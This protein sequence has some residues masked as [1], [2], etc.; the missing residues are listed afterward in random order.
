MI[1]TCFRVFS[2]FALVGLAA[3]FLSGCGGGASSTPEKD[4]DKGKDPGP[5]KDGKTDLGKPDF[6]L[7]SADYVAEFKKDGKAAHA[8]YKDKVVELTGKIVSVGMHPEGGGLLT[9]EGPDPK[10][11]DWA[12][13]ITTDPRPWK[14]ATPGQTVKVKGKGHPWFPGP[15]LLEGVVESVSGDAAP[16][17]TADEL[18]KEYAA[19]IEA[20]GKKYDSKWIVLSGEIDKND[21]KSAIV[22]KT[23]EKEPRVEARFMP[24]DFKRIQKWKAGDKVSVV[25]QYLLNNG[26]ESVQLISCLPMDDSK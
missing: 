25:G 26:K 21:G 3:L 12:Q 15:N 22:F 16:R 11:F 17:L 9:L 19:D 24:D 23:K 14:K 1:R 20:A 7:S 4:K 10:K 13:C 18:A 8:K 5:S 6:T 2:L